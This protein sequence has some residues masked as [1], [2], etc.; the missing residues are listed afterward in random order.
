[1][2]DGIPDWVSHVA[3]VEPPTNSNSSIWTVRT[4]RADEM[5]DA[6]GRYQAEVSASSSMPVSQ[7][8]IRN[9][10]EV[11]VQLK[12]VNVSYHERKASVSYVALSIAG[13]EFPRYYKIQTGQSERVKGGTFKDQTVCLSWSRLH[14][15]SG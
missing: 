4:G 3:F 6:I 7:S 14:L 10:G 9:D 2:Q 11:L 15:R 5:K 13:H 12:D 1:M 8:L